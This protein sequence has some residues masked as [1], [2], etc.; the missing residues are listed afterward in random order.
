MPAPARRHARLDLAAFDSEGRPVFLAE[1][2]AMTGAIAVAPDTLKDL[3]ANFH[4][5]GRSIPH[6]MIV[7]LDRVL[8][9]GIPD[10]GE[11]ALQFEAATADVLSVYEPAFWQKRIFRDD[12]VSLVNA[13]PH[14]LADRW[15]S[16][17]P[18]GLQPLTAIGLAERLRGGETHREVSIAQGDFLYRDQLLDE[19]LLGT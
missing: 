6:W 3:A 11:P 2:K 1:V 19:S 5:S 12:L 14:D 18:P 13:W 9:L 7:D 15:K 8:I 16:P 17:N 4:P 10:G